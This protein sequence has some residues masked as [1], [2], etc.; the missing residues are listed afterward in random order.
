MTSRRKIMDDLKDIIFLD[1]EI[2]E[3]DDDAPI[4]TLLNPAPA[5]EPETVDNSAPI[6]EDSPVEEVASGIEESEPTNEPAPV[7]DK[8]VAQ[9]DDTSAS[10]PASAPQVVEQANEPTSA[11]TPTQKKPRAT[12]KA[13]LIEQNNAPSPKIRK[14]KVD[15]V[16]GLDASN[17]LHESN[18]TIE[19]KPVQKKSD[20]V[21][22]KKKQEKSEDLWAVA[23]V[24]V[25]K[26][27]TKK[28][29]P[30]PTEEVK[31]TPKKKAAPKAEEPVAESTPAPKKKAPAK[32]K[33]NAPATSQSATNV[34]N[35]STKA[36]AKMAATK[37]PAKKPATKAEPV[38]EKVLV[39][40]D[41]VNP[42]G[43]FV[44]KHTDKG[45]YVYKLYSYNHRV[46]AIGAEQYSA[47][48]S[49][50]SGINSVMHNAASAPIEDLTLKT[51]VEQKCPKWVIYKDKK[52]EFRLR[53]LAS[54]GNI[55]ATT[56]DGYLSKDAAKK[57]IEAIARAAQ[58]ASIVRNDDLW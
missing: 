20:V 5:Q 28:A 11:P 48:P 25:K 8:E 46:V 38:Q 15:E 31:P 30:Q 39:E 41:P 27:P 34:E 6:V 49:C 24:V 36:E 55:V 13:T 32:A 50:K 35:K 54:N 21:S 18:F 45:N 10:E 17:A 14:S 1:A 52:E 26:A 47:L 2:V 3:D 7:V 57:G 58:G 44:I 56:N 37:E 22:T 43:K 42:H 19:E 4:G 51:P 12:K 40:G 29:D 53:L 33:A 9:K 16:G 23:P